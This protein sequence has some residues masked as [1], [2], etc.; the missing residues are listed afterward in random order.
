MEKLAQPTGG[1]RKGFIGFGLVAVLEFHGQ[2]QGFEEPGLFR[3]DHRRTKVHVDFFDHLHTQHLA[4]GQVGDG[5]EVGAV[6]VAAAADAPAFALH[7]DVILDVP[8]HA[9]LN[10]RLKEIFP[11]RYIFSSNA[12]RSAK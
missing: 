2:F 10:N 3:T 9:L 11:G 1:L 12:S 4:F 5:V 6:A 8:V 7:I